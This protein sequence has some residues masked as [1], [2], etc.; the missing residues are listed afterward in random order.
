MVAAIANL[1]DRTALITGVGSADGIGFAIARKLCDLGTAV[2]VTSASPRCL[3][4]AKELRFAGHRAE[5]AVCDL[6]DDAQV[7]QLVGTALAEFGRIDIL[8]NN[9][10]MTSIDD[11][12]PPSTPLHNLDAAH[13]RQQIER[14]LTTQFL[15]S[16]E[17]L[18]LMNTHHWGRIVNVASTTGTTGAMYGEAAYAAAKAAVVGLTKATALEYA[19]FGITCN[20]V[21]PGWIATESQT[22]HEAVQGLHTPVRRSGTPAEVAHVVAML[23][24]PDASYITGQCIV[25]DG[26]NSIAEERAH[27]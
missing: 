15:V 9:A 3:D 24:L 13:W 7:T 14:T 11:P 4:R 1:E 10:G 17:V 16:S 23:C 12:I 18:P 21:A 19:S 27:P 25:V 20:A 8:V 5:A 26:G 2:F 6:T 22:K